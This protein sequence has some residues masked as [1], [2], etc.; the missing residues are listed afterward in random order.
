MTDSGY[1][2]MDNIDQYPRIM[3]ANYRTDTKKVPDM[4]FDC[5]NK[6][7]PT[8]YKHLG[9]IKLAMKEGTVFY[10]YITRVTWSGVQVYLGVS[11]TVTCDL[12]TASVGP[13]SYYDTLTQKYTGSSNKIDQ[14]SNAVGNS[15]CK[16]NHLIQPLCGVDARHGYY[17]CSN[18]RYCIGQDIIRST[19]FNTSAPDAV[20]QHFFSWN[21]THNTTIS[22]NFKVDTWTSETFNGTITQETDSE[23]LHDRITGRYIGVPDIRN[24]EGQRIFYD[25]YTQ[26][27]WTEAETLVSYINSDTIQL[28]ESVTIPPIPS[29]PILAASPSYMQMREHVIRESMRSQHR[30]ANLLNDYTYNAHAPENEPKRVRRGFFSGIGDFFGGILGRVKCA[31]SSL[32]G[33]NCGG[34]NKQALEDEAKAI[35]ATNDAVRKTNGRIDLL[36][37]SQESIKKIARSALSE[38]INNAR[39]LKNL[40]DQL[41]EVAKKANDGLIN[42]LRISIQYTNLLQQFQHYQN[43]I[44]NQIQLAEQMVQLVSMNGGR[45]PD[46]SSIFKHFKGSASFNVRLQRMHDCFFLPSRIY[47]KHDGF[48]VVL[49]FR[50]PKTSDKYTLYR[51]TPLIGSHNGKVFT[52]PQ[53][54]VKDTVLMATDSFITSCSKEIDT[55][56]GKF[57]MDPKHIKGLSSG[58]KCIVHRMLATTNEQLQACSLKTESQI[59]CQKYMVSPFTADFWHKDQPLFPWSTYDKTY[60]DRHPPKAVFPYALISGSLAMT[61]VPSIVYS[62]PFINH[63]L[64]AFYFFTLSPQAGSVIPLSSIYSRTRYASV[65]LPPSTGKVDNEFGSNVVVVISSQHPTGNSRAIAQGFGQT[66]ALQKYAEKYNKAFK[67]SVDE[68]VNNTLERVS[69]YEREYNRTLKAVDSLHDEVDE[70]LDH[71]DDLANKAADEATD[72]G[73]DKYHFMKWINLGLALAAD[74]GVIAIVF[75]MFNKAEATTPAP[76]HE[77]ALSN[78][79]PHIIAGMLAVGF[80]VVFGFTLKVACTKKFPGKKFLAMLYVNTMIVL[81]TIEHMSDVIDFTNFHNLFTDQFL[82][83]FCFIMHG[84][85]ALLFMVVASF[86]GAANS[87]VI[88]TTTSKPTVNFDIKEVEEEIKKVINGDIDANRHWFHK[89]ES[90]NQQRWAFMSFTLMFFILVGCLI[91]YIITMKRTGIPNTWKAT[92]WN[93]FKSLFQKLKPIAVQVSG[94]PVSIGNNRQMYQYTYFI[95][96]ASDPTKVTEVIIPNN[97]VRGTKAIIAGDV[98]RRT[99][100]LDHMYEQYSNYENVKQQ[101]C[102]IDNGSVVCIPCEIKTGDFSDKAKRTVLKKAAYLRAQTQADQDI[103]S[104]PVLSLEPHAIAIGQDNE[105]DVASDEQAPSSS[106]SSQ[107]EVE[108]PPLST[109]VT[110]GLFVCSDITFRRLQYYAQSKGI[111]FPSN[112]LTF[113][114]HRQRYLTALGYTD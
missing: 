57:N 108:K 74:C 77:T 96:W 27:I 107:R 60:L 66:T 113:S 68:Q 71:S 100:N 82:L 92:K 21:K 103:R 104:R 40:S 84:F 78:V 42:S 11:H 73:D 69:R 19:S 5:A 37:K 95:G 44:N 80:T 6:D 79:M 93:R 81:F 52:Q 102:T 105:T 94:S 43:E 26:S 35:K 61:L 88:P 99:V 70:Q 91:F 50:C 76:I 64:P 48:H 38:S 67:R 86:I 10:V 63:K 39:N 65:K 12:F 28:V 33:D 30:M 41:V 15:K 55:P 24:A 13:E 23:L 98:K 1:L 56:V 14:F 46:V 45:F 22:E 101:I 8:D 3:A 2:N 18:N 29:Y 53:Q 20:H 75:I 17:R 36:V 4:D 112:K 16:S 114:Q 7:M 72:G 47:T 34:S 62:P 110:N 49:N 90:I 87:F 111:E 109:I 25:E 32:L 9:F 58:G 59:I 89:Y 51:P 54:E 97:H 85:C 31:V 106:T 83:I